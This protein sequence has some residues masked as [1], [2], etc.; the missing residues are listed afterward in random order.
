MTWT[1]FTVSP[2]S[3]TLGYDV[4]VP[5]AITSYVTVDASTLTFK[6]HVSDTTL[7]S[8][9]GAYEITITAKTP[10]GTA[11]SNTTLKVSLTIKELC[12]PPAGVTPPALTFEMHKIGDVEKTVLTWPAF[13]SDPSTCNLGYDVNV[14]VNIASLITVDNSSRTI[15]AGVASDTFCGKVT[16]SVIT[17][18]AQSPNGV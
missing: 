3:C 1:A 2:A 5:A 17:I 8:L 10:T 16:Y 11:I 14:P 15:K 12:E 13:T 18:T 7:T 4:V 9:A 6:V